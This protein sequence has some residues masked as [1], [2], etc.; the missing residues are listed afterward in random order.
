MADYVTHD[1]YAGREKLCDERFARDKHQIEEHEGMLREMRSCN[2]R[3]TEMIERHDAE[4]KDHGKRLTV[5]EY[6][7]ADT[8]GKLKLAFLTA[9]ISGVA[10]Y[11]VSAVVAATK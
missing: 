5:I 9:I 6:K 3:L 7:P 4:L 8:W 1:E 2:I 11:V 10:G